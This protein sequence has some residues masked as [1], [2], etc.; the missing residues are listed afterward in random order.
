VISACEAWWRETAGRIKPH[1][2]IGRQLEAMVTALPGAQL[3]SWTV[4]ACCGSYPLEVIGSSLHGDDFTPLPG[5][6]LVLSVA[7][8]V[9]GMPWFTAA[10]FIVREDGLHDLAHAN[11]GR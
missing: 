11:V 5:R 3:R 8:N 10:P 4:E 7:L 1:A 6:M 2:G 9:E